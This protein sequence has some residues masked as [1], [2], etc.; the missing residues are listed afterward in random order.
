MQRHHH[1]QTRTEWWQAK[2]DRNVTNDRKHQAQLAE[3]GWN[4]IVIWE[5]ELKDPD[6]A[7]TRLLAE[8]SRAVTQSKQ[9]PTAEEV[10][11][12]KAAE[13]KATYKT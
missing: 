8:L 6:A 12:L 9:Y 3:Q 10:A 4:V 11:L 2:F 1:P 5:C 7:L 13:K